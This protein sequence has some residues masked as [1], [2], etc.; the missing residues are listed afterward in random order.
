MN[1]TNQVQYSSIKGP[2]FLPFVSEEDGRS[3]YTVYITIQLS[4]M[5]VRCQKHVAYGAI[6]LCQRTATS[7]TRC[8]FALIAA[9]EDG[10]L[11]F[12]EYP[13]FPTVSVCLAFPT[14]RTGLTPVGSLRK[15][16]AELNGYEDCRPHNINRLV[17]LLLRR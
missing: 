7:Q 17:H 16:R 3:L 9:T 1:L 10:Q 4:R 8:N 5:I 14:A 2:S 13:G 15:E 11:F 6:D 12:V